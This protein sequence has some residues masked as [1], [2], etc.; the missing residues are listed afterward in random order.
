MSSTRRELPHLEH[1]FLTALK[2]NDIGGLTQF[3]EQ[4]A[5]FTLQLEQAA[6]TDF[7]SRDELDAHLC[8][9]RNVYIA[10]SQAEQITLDMD[11]LSAKFTQKLSLLAPLA[12]SPPAPSPTP[13]KQSVPED[14]S[15]SSTSHTILKNWSQA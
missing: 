12:P 8:L 4:F 1:G 2:S 10:S 13:L 11:E 6:P 15:S 3:G 14:A 7:L 9:S 5:Q